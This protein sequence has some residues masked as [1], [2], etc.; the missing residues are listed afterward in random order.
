MGVD[1]GPITIS[2]GTALEEKKF[3]SVFERRKLKLMWGKVKC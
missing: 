2:D 1:G 3:G